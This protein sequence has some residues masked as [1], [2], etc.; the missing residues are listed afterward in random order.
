MLIFHTV[1][2]VLALLAG[3]PIFF[4][5]NGHS[6]FFEVLPPGLPFTSRAALLWGMPYIVGTILI[7][8]K[9]SFFKTRFGGPVSGAAC[10]RDLLSTS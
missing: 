6:H 8:W 9:R 4:S 7:Y 3:F 10:P 1:T 2:A 5:E